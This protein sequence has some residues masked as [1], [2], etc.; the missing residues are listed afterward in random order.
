M[1]YGMSLSDLQT[2]LTCSVAVDLFITVI[3]VYSVRTA[4]TLL[5][6]ERS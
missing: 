5:H 6:E 1:L 3:L 4:A 2:W